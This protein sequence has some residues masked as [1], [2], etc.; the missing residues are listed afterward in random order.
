[1]LS[2]LSEQK[3]TASVDMLQNEPATVQIRI[4]HPAT[5]IKD[6]FPTV[7]NGQN[8][9]ILVSKNKMWQGSLN[10]TLNKCDCSHFTPN[11][12]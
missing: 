12:S 1:M 9:F 10:L 6:L 8:T 5:L 3:P 2:Y 7:F 4:Q 11:C